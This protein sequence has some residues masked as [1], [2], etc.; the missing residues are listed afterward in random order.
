MKLRFI[1]FALVVGLCGSGRLLGFSFGEKHVAASLVA[2]RTALVPGHT[3]TVAL[4][5]VHDE[6]WHTYWKN[7]GEAGLPTT[8]SWT[9]PP[10][11]SAGPIQWPAPQITDTGGVLTYGYGGDLLLLV[12]IAV[13]ADARAGENVVLAAKTE[14][15]MCKESCIPGEAQVSLTLP[16]AAEAATDTQWAARIAAARAT[17]PQRS[18]RLEARA[19]R[20]GRDL[21]IRVSPAAGVQLAAGSVGFFA[22]DGTV[23]AQ[24]LQPA[25][26]AGA[27]FDF[28][29]RQAQT[30]GQPKELTGLLVAADGWWSG[31]PKA[32]AVQ[33]PVTDG[34]APVTG[35][36]AATGQGAGP[37]TEKSDA[38]A[39]TGV[40]VLAF[41]GGLILNLMPCVF[42]VLGIKILGFVQQAGAERGKVRAHGLAFAAGVLASFWTLAGV[43]LALRAGGAQLG[44]GYQLQVPGFVFVLTIVMLV[45]ALSLSGVFEIGGSLIGAGAGLQAKSGYAGSFFSGVLA[46]VVATPCSA[47]FLAPALGAAIVLPPVQSLAAFTAI[48]LGLAAPYLV[49]SFAPALVKVLPRPGAWMETFKQFMAFPLYATAGYLVYVLAGQVGDG[50]LEVVLG[51]TL[52][53]MAGWVIGRWATLM[54]A[55]RV[56]WIARGAALALFAG[57]I[58]LGLP[59]QKVDWV[60]WSP[61]TVAKLRA[62]DRIV[63]VDFTARW[64][65]TCQANKAVV[66]GSAEV[67]EAFR[68]LKVAKVRGDWTSRDPQIAAELQRFGRAAVPVTLV[69]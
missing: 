53:A 61:E 65:V 4:R 52:I 32:V 5:L 66:F 30:A 47:P 63:Y 35:V 19:Y 2:E 34:P 46:T 14:W 44:W 13:S 69:Y 16:V 39:F 59:R 51:L 64:C 31:G 56:R 42:P 8:L 28:A 40:L 18:D 25:R 23:D 17:L 24:A 22:D 49:L 12:D 7:P 55:A 6:H 41:V 54:R 10:G 26:A 60:P 9:L 48:A 43:L 37:A 11:F 1:L 58:V 29:V 62:Q 45:F 67:N 68:S 20:T 15:L 27:A 21:T 3:T 36:A 57:G 33:I 38:G 50:L